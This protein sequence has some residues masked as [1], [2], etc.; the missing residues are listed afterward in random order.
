MALKI[1][2]LDT[3]TISE[4]IKP[5]PNHNVIHQLDALSEFSAIGVTT[6]Y[7]IQKGI[8]VMPEGRRKQE[9][10]YFYQNE[11]LPVFPVLPYDQKAA[12]V[13]A[14]IFGRLKEKGTPVPYEDCQLAAIAISNNL[15]LVTRN[16]KH[17]QKIAEVFNFGMENW[18]EEK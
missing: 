18:F 9:L 4:A 2:L 10:A 13:Q 15:I 14:E 7:E 3:N 1:Y 17:F 16:T 11:I 5:N 8:A 6:S 12:S